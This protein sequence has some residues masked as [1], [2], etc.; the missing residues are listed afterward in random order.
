[1]CSNQENLQTDDQKDEVSNGL[2]SATTGGSNFNPDSI[3]KLLDMLRFLIQP[4]QQPVRRRRRRSAS[5]QEVQMQTPA[6][7]TEM[8][9]AVMESSVVAIF[10]V[11][12]DSVLFT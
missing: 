4:Q 2:A 5:T 1:M 11:Y 8:Q 6:Q 3:K 7:V 12:S 9:Y 10:V